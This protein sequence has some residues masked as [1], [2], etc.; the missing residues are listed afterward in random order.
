MC[1]RRSE[2]ALAHG[3]KSYNSLMSYN[4]HTVIRYFLHRALCFSVKGGDGI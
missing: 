3:N 1:E 4:Y 2:R